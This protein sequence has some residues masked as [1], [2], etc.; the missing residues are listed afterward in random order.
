M[1]ILLTT[2]QFFPQFSAGTEVLT[3][4]VAHE[5]MKRGHIVHV[6]TGFPSIENLTDK[7][8]FD[9]Y[10]YQGVHIYR[11]HHAYTPMSGQTSMIEIG[12]NNQL[13]AKLFESILGN[14]KPN[15]VHFFHLNRLGTNL[16]DSA[17]QF[18]I[19]CF[20]TA[21][22]FWVICSTGQLVLQNGTLCSGPNCDSGNCVKHLAVS[23]ISDSAALYLEWIPTSFIDLL[24]RL[25]KKGRL[26][27]YPQSIEV[28]AI[29]KR[30]P[31]NIERINQLKKII[32]P[33]HIMTEKLIE[34]GVSPDLIIQSAFGINLN[35]QKNK[36]RDYKFL[37]PYKIG[38]IG[39]LAQHKGCH[40]LIEAFKLLPANCCTL[41]IFG[42]L[43]DF[44]EYVAKLTNLSNNQRNI[45]FC[46]TFPNAEIANVLDDIDILVV[47]SLWFENTPLVLYSAQAARCPVIA[48]DF[49]GITEVITDGVN[50]LLFEA[51]NSK[52][53]A[54]NLLKLI[55]N[56]SLAEKLSANTKQPKTINR[57]VDELLEIWR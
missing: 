20:F 13:A 40:I 38:Y 10:D 31:T 49:Q 43:D 12:Y 1:K 19:P 9:E 6:F 4:S 8:R 24:V 35:N 48:S 5:L 51:G 16:I 45:K 28:K 44:P 11:F 14:F 17:N 2:H 32:S 53:L 54:E 41:K 27:F 7:E 23:R 50:G 34:Y 55:Y 42:K 36:V 21:T 25:T 15:I 22:D 56:P 57:Y 3:L 29:N 30:L 39:T 18:D 47:P 33:T 52:A 26:P 46:G 37:S